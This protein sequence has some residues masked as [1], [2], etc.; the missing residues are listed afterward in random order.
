MAVRVTMICKTFSVGLMLYNVSIIIIIV[1]SVLPLAG[2]WHLILF[3][4]LSPVSSFDW[5]LHGIPRDTIV[6]HRPWYS[7]GFLPIE[8]AHEIEGRFLAFVPYL[9]GDLFFCD[10]LPRPSSVSVTQSKSIFS[11]NSPSVL[12]KSQLT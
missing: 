9:T 10:E 7:P 5:V 12:N 2:P 4:S 1:I 6:V 8:G 11:A 3:L